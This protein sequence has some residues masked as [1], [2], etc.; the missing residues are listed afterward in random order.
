M[1]D[2]SVR[3]DFREVELGSQ[4]EI[5]KACV[6]SKYVDEYE[7][8][9]TD[10]DAVGSG[11][12]VG[13]IIIDEEVCIERKSPSDFVVSM[14]EGHL[15]D[16]LARMYERYDH[17]FVLVSGTFAETARVPHSRIKPQ[18]VRAFVASMAVRWDTTPLFCGDERRLAFTAIDLGRK[19]KEPLERRPGKP[20]I[21]VNDDLSPVGKAAM[22][23]DGIGPET[24]ERVEQRFLT[25]G[26]LCGASED[27]L[28]EI[29][30]I[31]PK[32]ARKISRVLQ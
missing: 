7:I 9:N 6:E 32:T 11:L 30:G 17:V 12:E 2:L 23:A 20:Q 26:E 19:V 28:A 24:A 31:G 1:A 10:E 5:L 18:A 29:E 13:D 4:Q 21:D 25:V 16:Q 27:K 3:I 8:V 22:L 15:E 14:K